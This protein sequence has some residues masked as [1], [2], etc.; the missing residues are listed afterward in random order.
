MN[1]GNTFARLQV[2]KLYRRDQRS[3][4]EQVQALIAA[5]PELSAKGPAEKKQ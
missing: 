4:D 2:Y 3:L 1:K 5:N